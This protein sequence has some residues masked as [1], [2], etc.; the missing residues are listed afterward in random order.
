MR[1]GL[2]TLGLVGVVT[3]PAAIAGRHPT[4][5]D[6]G[7]LGGNP[8]I[9]A[10]SDQGPSSDL[11]AWTMDPKSGARFEAT[12]Q[13]SVMSVVPYFDAVRLERVEGI[14]KTDCGVF[15]QPILRESGAHR[16]WVYTRDRP[17]SGTCAGGGG[18]GYVAVGS[19]NSV[20]F[21]TVPVP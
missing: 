19:R 6:P 9:G 2:L 10:T 7:P 11:I 15:N 13:S 5:A 18:G 16:Y 14:T 12:L 17:T 4:R 20:E 8:P 3:L 1:L 21:R